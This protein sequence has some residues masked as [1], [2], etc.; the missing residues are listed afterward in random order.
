MLSRRRKDKPDDQLVFCSGLALSRLKTST[1]PASRRCPPSGKPFSTR[2]SRFV[3]L[4]MRRVPMGS[5]RTERV[6][7][8]LGRHKCAPEGLP[9]LMPQERGDPDVPRTGVRAVNPGRPNPKLVPPILIGI[10]KVV[11]RQRIRVLADGLPKYPLACSR[12]QVCANP[13]T[14]DHLPV[15]RRVAVISHVQ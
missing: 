11:R 4:S 10:D 3:L 8:V 15:K 12:V 7:V 2:T 14:S 1:N 5:A 9:G 13:A 6:G